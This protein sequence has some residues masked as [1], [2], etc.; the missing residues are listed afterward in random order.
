MNDATA[1]GG[2]ADLVRNGGTLCLDYINT[3]EPRTGPVSREWLTGYPDLV[4]WARRGGLVDEAAAGALLRAAAARPAAARAAFETAINLREGLFRLFAA[5]VDNT[6]PA[7][8]DLEVLRGAFAA[9]TQHGRLVPRAGGFGWD[10]DAAAR[11]GDASTDRLGRPWW[12]VAASAME[13]LTH[14]PLDRIK[15]CPTDE[16]CSWLFVDTTKNRS[17][18]WCS[19]D[20]CGSQIKA[21]RQTDQRRAA[22]RRTR[23]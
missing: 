5:I 18:R 9:A 13:L 22:R 3:V 20:D 1:T 8:A 19:M 15:Q 6:A 23:A 17:R 7:D 10:F 11:A 21:R 16:G 12:P 2:V 4:E 14:G